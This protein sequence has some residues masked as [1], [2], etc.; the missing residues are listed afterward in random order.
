MK[1]YQVVVLDPNGVG[2]DHTQYIEK[3]AAL[4]FISQK[5]END[6]SVLIQINMIE[7][8]KL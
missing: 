8:G 3:D 2:A 7:G 5:I 6:D 4:K 1:L